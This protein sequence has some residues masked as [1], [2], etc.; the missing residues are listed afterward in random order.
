MYDGRAYEH[1]NTMRIYDRKLG[2]FKVLN[3]MRMYDRQFKNKL[4]MYD[5]LS[6]DIESE[7]LVR[8]YNGNTGYE[9]WGPKLGE[10]E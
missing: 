9:E 2:E 7:S 8:V 3:L 6:G 4:R 1:L 10:N 5:G